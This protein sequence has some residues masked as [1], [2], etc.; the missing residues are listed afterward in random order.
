MHDKTRLR[1]LAVE[2][3]LPR[4]E[5]HEQ[6]TEVRKQRRSI[7]KLAELELTC[8]TP[9]ARAEGKVARTQPFM[10]SDDGGGGMRVAALLACSADVQTSAR[11]SCWTAIS[12]STAPRYTSGRCN[13]CSQASQ[14]RGLPVDAS[15]TQKP[16]VT[17]G[18]VSASPS[19]S[20]STTLSCRT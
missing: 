1:K 9:C 6:H 11:R 14:G 7:T 2:G 12:A 3:D 15:T 4:L 19:S 13:Q 16:M 17:S 8:T 10:H 20:P 18:L 5:A